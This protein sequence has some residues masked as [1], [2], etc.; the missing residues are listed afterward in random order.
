MRQKAARARKLEEQRRMAKRRNFLNRIILTV[1]VVAVVIGTALAFISTAQTP[2]S[3]TTTSSTTTTTTLPAAQVKA[4]EAAQ[5]RVNHEAVAAGCPASPMTVVNTL[6][7]SKPP[8]RTIDPSDN[9]YAT[10]DTT[11]GTFVVQLDPKVAPVTVN[12]F[13]FLADHR[14]YNCVIFQRV[15][16]DFMFQGGDPTGTGSGTLGYTIPDEYPKKAGNPTYPLYSIAM[17]NELSP[18]TGSDQFFIVTGSEGET[19]PPSYTLFGRII[20]GE[21]V[22]QTIVSYGQESGTPLVIE[23]M[24]K[25][26]ISMTAPAGAS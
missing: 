14:F 23:R 12:N 13:V 16:P 2:K 21:K 22:A 10:F 15:I 9:Y 3:T 20:T 26:T 11:A 4:D 7:W 19:L 17:A 8:K 6:H 25:V 24:L 5:V 18:H 1:V